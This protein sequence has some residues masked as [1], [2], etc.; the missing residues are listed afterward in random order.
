[1]V[2]VIINFHYKREAAFRVCRSPHVAEDSSS[3]PILLFLDG[4][5]GW[6]RCDEMIKRGDPV[7]RRLGIM[8]CNGAF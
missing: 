5:E 1:M 3:P 2:K 8:Q 6:V 7:V 4:G